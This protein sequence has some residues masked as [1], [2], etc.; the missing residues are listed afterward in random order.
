[1]KKH[2]IKSFIAIVMIIA[3]SIITNKKLTPSNPWQDLCNYWCNPHPTARCEL[4]VGIPEGIY[5]VTCYY[6]VWPE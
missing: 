4:L 5:R 1:M 6:K 2:L 3:I